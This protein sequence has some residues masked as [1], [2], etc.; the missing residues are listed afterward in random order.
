MIADLQQTAH[1]RTMTQCFRPSL[2][3]SK[4]LKRIKEKRRNI[5]IP[6]FRVK[7]M[8]IAQKV[9]RSPKLIKFFKENK[10]RIK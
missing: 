2:K 8:E 3:P 1:N 9:E 4:E 10:V 6:F 7:G 5:K